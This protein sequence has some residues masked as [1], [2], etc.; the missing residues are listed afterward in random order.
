MK[1]LV[2]TGSN[3]W[4]TLSAKIVRPW[5]ALK[6]K[7]PA[8]LAAAFGDAPA[9]VKQIDEVFHHVLNLLRARVDGIDFEAWIAHAP[10]RQAMNSTVILQTFRSEEVGVGHLVVGRAGPAAAR[11]RARRGR[12][13]RARSTWRHSI[14]PSQRC[15]P[16]QRSPATF[17]RS[18]QDHD[19]RMQLGDN[20][21]PQLFHHGGA[22]RPGERLSRRR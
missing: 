12:D 3:V 7:E 14:R 18:A 19:E 2:A 8:R 9:L 17:P 4:V 1:S 22:R 20:V 5:N 11:S 10:R 6:V 15:A 16:R 21:V 13:D